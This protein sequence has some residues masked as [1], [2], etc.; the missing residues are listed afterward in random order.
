MPAFWSGSG[1]DLLERRSDGRLAITDP[2]LRSY[3]LRPELA[4]IPS[5]DTAELRLHQR[6]LDEPRRAVGRDE[7][8]ALADPDARENYR[9]W[10]RFRQRLLDAPS[11][12]ACYLALFA[13]EGVDVAP[14]FVHQLTQLV[15]RHILTGDAPAFHARAAEMLFRSQ[16]VTVQ[17]DGAVIAADEQTVEIYA[18][19]GF[20]SVGELL[21]AQRTPTRTIELDVLSTDNADTYW[22]RDERFDLALS[23]NRGQPGLDALCRVLEAWIFHFLAVIVHIRPV[24]EIDDHRWV[25]H[26]GLD[27]EASLLLNDLYNKVEV[28]EERMGRLL[29]LFELRFEHASD[30]RELIGERAVY[31]AMAMDSVHRLRLKPQ[32]L[33][34][35]LPLAPAQ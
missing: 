8:D 29:C 17:P 19:G 11:L 4:P 21:V 14:L 6:L 31:M 15:L 34:L 35:N 28:G 24:R 10:L 13:G 16:K 20:G 32:N 3:L 9:I 30:A 22:T 1:Y 27:A 2:F 18:T 26:L 33:L 5:S 23:L 7:L 12:E 25:W